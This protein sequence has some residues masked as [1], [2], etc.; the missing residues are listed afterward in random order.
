L[1]EQKKVKLRFNPEEAQPAR[2]FDLELQDANGSPLWLTH[3]DPDIDVAVIPINAQ[4]L[5]EQ[6]IK[7]HWFQSDQ[8]IADR[9]KASQLGITE[10]DGIFVLG[11]P[12]GLIGGERNFVIVR[13]GVIARIRDALSGSS[14]EF[15]ADTFIF[16]GNS[17][18]PVVTK[19]E[20]TAITGTQ[21][22][23]SA[24]LIGVVKGYITYHDV[25]TSTQTGRPRVT[26]EENSGL[27]AVIPID[28]VKEVIQEHMKTLKQGPGD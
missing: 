12:L 13:Q 25:A 27:T 2:E 5:K 23:T 9:A 8:H 7:F 19:P 18:G 17:G 10:G 3:P 1:R 14:K 26:F 22:V 24:Y 16:P 11:F 21:A 15:L 20:P 28:F 6:K 4:F